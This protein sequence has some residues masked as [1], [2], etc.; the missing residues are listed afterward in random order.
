MP[1]DLNL[2]D[3]LLGGK[4]FWRR[5]LDVL[6]LIEAVVN[7]ECVACLEM[8]ELLCLGPGMGPKATGIRQ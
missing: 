1:G 4:R 2:Y 3:V 7:V 6:N 8:P 5:V